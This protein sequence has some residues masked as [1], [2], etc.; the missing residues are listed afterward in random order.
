[1]DGNRRLGWIAIAIGVVALVVA[2][3]GRGRDGRFAGND[4]GWQ[5]HG[6]YGQL[7]GQPADGFGRGDQQ[8]GQ[9]PFG[10]GRDEFGP[11]RGEF[12]PGRGAFGP[13]HSPFGFF[14]LPFMLLGGLFKLALV[15]MAVFLVAQLVRRGRRGGPGGPGGPFGRRGHNW[16]HGPQQTDAPATPPAPH[17]PG[18]ETYTGETTN[19]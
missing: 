2:V 11:G 18:P 19:L 8:G 10:P 15:G 16:P 14:L 1:M 9:P 6:G 13:R 7:Q 12:G 5:D 17:R 4:H 3:S